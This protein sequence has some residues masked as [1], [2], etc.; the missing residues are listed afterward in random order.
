MLNRLYQFFIVLLCLAGVSVA[1]IAPVTGLRENTPTVHAFTNARIVTAPGKVIPKGTLVI[2]NA[3]IEAVGDKVVPP[4]DARVWDL[5]GQTLYAAFIDVASDIGLP[6]PQP[7]QQGGPPFGGG[8]PAPAPEQAKGAAHWN[9]KVRADFDASEEFASDTKAAEKLRSQGFGMAVTIPSRGI[10]RGTSALVSLGEGAPTDL[11]VKGQ[12][13]Q[14]VTFDQT[15]DFFS[16]YPNSLMGI[17]ALVRQTW[18]D[19]DWYR[20]AHEA[21]AKNP[22]GQKR[23]ETNAALA[24]LVDASLGRQPVVFD[25]S[26]DINFLRAAKIAKEFS[27]TTWV[28]GSGEEYR[29]L[30]AIKAT[31]IPVI[32]PLEF[33][34]APSVDSPEDALNVSLEDLLHW[35]AAPENAARLEKAGVSFTLTTAKLKDA[36]T[37]LAQARKAVERGLS[38]DGALAA[39]TTTPAKW[40]GMDKRIGSLEVG[41]AAN[42]LITDGDVFAEKTKVR[43]VWIDGK[44]YAVKIPP[45]NDPR[46]AWDVTFTTATPESGSMTLRGEQE[47]P[48]GTLKWRG[49]DLKIATGAFSA[50]RLTLTMSGDSIGAAGTIRLSATVSEKEMFGG[51]E[52]PDGTVLHW[53]AQ[54]KGPPGEEPDT[55]KPKT[56]EMA[57]FPDVYPPGEYGRQKPPEQPQSLLVKNATIWTQGP[58]G[59]LANADL[60]VSKG[61]IKQI[62]SNLTAPKDGV[63]I[64]ATGKQVTPGLIDCHS[65]TATSSVNEGGQAITA[66]TRIEDV[67]DPDDIWIYRQLAGGTTA[68]NILHG[69][70]NPI[71]GQNGVVKWRW[72]S[73]AD[74]LLIAGAP[75]GIKFALGENVKQSNFMPGGR[76]STR[77]PQTRM[78]VEQIIRDRFQA[79]LDYE[80]EWKEWE[81][82]KRRL[83]PRRD[84]ELDALVEILRGKRLVHAHSYRQ[85][86]I[87]MLIRVAEDFGF[88]IATFQHVLEGYKVA[89]AMAKHGAG[90]STFSD[91]WAYKIEAWDAIPGNGPLMRS[92]GVVVS[93][94]S[95]NSQLATRMNWEAS[96]AVRFGLTEEEALKFVTIN[97][98]KQLRIDDKVGSLEVGKDADFVIWNGNPLST[99]SKCEQTWV[100]GKKYFDLEEDQ[101]S[102]ERIKKER[103]VLIQKILASKKERPTT[104]AGPAMRFR[105]PNEVFLQSCMEGVNYETH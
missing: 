94:N 102:R 84:L 69:S 67:I 64:D 25:V 46:G 41:K 2:R 63:V 68:A 30:D 56:I 24:A 65:H 53:S 82:D 86:E 62:G 74:D 54:R 83:I 17:I 40:L 85:D 3:V 93:Y 49:K 66:E 23:P 16:G 35:D 71:G 8:T 88:K 29:R 47:K 75:P 7:S 19:T 27:L 104:P 18:Y 14:N 31:K 70:A 10:F 21:Y 97:P 103:A 34:E 5:S 37:F 61:K 92:Q 77:Y 78:G 95:D 48:T 55:T 32:V 13:A 96:K 20:K 42:I 12:V 90:G 52:L 6:K 36:G 59:K 22:Q 58:Q 98:A 105:R 80:R 89:D 28:L 44:Q 15:G 33:P 72:G 73:L 26:D 81:K 76:P 4:A 100:D 45:T 99:F 87:L 60:L 39:L 57:S 50:G 9:A 91:W 11:V 79:A 38:A 51:G 101:Q 43:E 1:Q